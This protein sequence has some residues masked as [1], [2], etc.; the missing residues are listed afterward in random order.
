[1]DNDVELPLP[2]DTVARDIVQVSAWKGDGMEVLLERVEKLLQSFRRSMTALVPYTEGSLI[3][4]VHGRCEIIKEEH[5]A[6]GVLLEV[7]V[8]EESANRLAK[9]K[10]EE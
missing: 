1:M 9:F 5:T 10:V 8:D 3:G 7:Y 2:M 4:W 6:E